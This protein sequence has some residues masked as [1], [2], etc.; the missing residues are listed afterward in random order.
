[1]NA[2]TLSITTMALGV[3]IGITGTHYQQVNKLVAQGIP[4]PVAPPLDRALEETPVYREN[5][6]PQR[7]FTL[8]SSDVAEPRQSTLPMMAESG[9]YREDALLEILANIR[10]EQKTI[11][12]QLSE[13]NRDIDE[14]TFRVDTHSDSFK[15]LRTE[16]VRPRPLD[17][18]L[19]PMMDE[20]GTDL[21]PPKQ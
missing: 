21:L 5:P 14:L 13:S 7:P 12:R 4:A 11:R 9:N 6:T 1:M 10:N 3:M 17:S 20:G 18:P 16:V 8:A 15:P 2:T 19:Q